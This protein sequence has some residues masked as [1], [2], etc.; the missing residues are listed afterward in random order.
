MHDFSSLPTLATASLLR[1]TL[2]PLHNKTKSENKFPPSESQPQTATL[3][4]SGSATQQALFLIVGCRKFL[5][6]IR[7]SAGRRQH[8]QLHQCIKTTTPNQARLPLRMRTLHSWRRWGTF[9]RIAQTQAWPS[10]CW[11]AVTLQAGARQLCEMTPPE[12]TSPTQRQARARTRRVSMSKTQAER[13]VRG[14]KTSMR[15]FSLRLSNFER[16]KPKRSKRT[17]SRRPAW[18]L[19]SPT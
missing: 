15:G 11:K 8:C 13:V 2:G 1:H 6:R 17:A 9:I 7:S 16:R 5:G 14:A 19:V 12:L 18:V 10:M 4:Q 3:K